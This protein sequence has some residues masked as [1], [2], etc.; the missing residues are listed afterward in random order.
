MNK[1]K[2]FREKTTGLRCNTEIYFTED[3]EDIDTIWVR[4]TVEEIINLVNSDQ[5]FIKLY[6]TNGEIDIY[7]NKN[8]IKLFHKI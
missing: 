6:D 5:L 1:L 4:E 3:T 7:V 2:E 8:T